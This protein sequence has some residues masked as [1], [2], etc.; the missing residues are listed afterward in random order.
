MIVCQ[1]LIPL[2]CEVLAVD[3]HLLSIEAAFR[4]DAGDRRWRRS[5]FRHDVEARVEGLAVGIFHPNDVFAIWCVI[6]NRRG[7]TRSAARR[8]V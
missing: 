2:R 6:G 3:G 1:N 8:Y 4:A 5:F 7:E